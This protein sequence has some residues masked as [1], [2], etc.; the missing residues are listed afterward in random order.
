MQALPGK[1]SMARLKEKLVELAWVRVTNVY[2]VTA[3]SQVRLTEAAMP[4]E[5]VAIDATNCAR[6]T[7]FREAERVAQYRAKLAAG[8]VGYFT[9]GPAGMLGSIWATVNRGDVPLVVRQ[10]MRLAPG[11]ALIHDIVTGEESRGQGVGSF[12]TAHMVRAL[13]AMRGIGRVVIDVRVGNDGS[14]RMMEKIGLARAER[15]AFLTLFKRRAAALRL[16]GS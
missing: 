2:Y 7:E 16:A 11:D 1:S 15:M 5:F 13:L 14:N 4:C 12:M 8:E 6:V 10:Y 9:Q 3:P